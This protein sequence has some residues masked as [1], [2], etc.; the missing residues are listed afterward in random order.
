MAERGDEENESLRR[1]RKNPRMV[2]ERSRR[3]PVLDDTS[4]EVVR[5]GERAEERG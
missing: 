2:M 3:A 1:M 4:D 5:D